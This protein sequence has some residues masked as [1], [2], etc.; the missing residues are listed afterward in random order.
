MS[1]VSGK[2]GHDFIYCVCVDSRDK[3]FR[4]I[5]HVTIGQEIQSCHNVSQCARKMKN[6][7]AFLS[8]INVHCNIQAHN[9]H[10]RSSSSKA[11]SLFVHHSF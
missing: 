1:Q 4:Q 9:L 8:K 2:K 6:M 10:L 3:I 7:A 11:S 5:N